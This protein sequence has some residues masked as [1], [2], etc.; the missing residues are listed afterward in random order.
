M[1]MNN[2]L[3]YFNKDFDNNISKSVLSRAVTY[4]RISSEGQS[5]FS[6]DSQ[7]KMVNDFCELNCIEIVKEFG[8]THESAKSDLSLIHI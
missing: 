6:I 5:N 4:T 7:V 1:T 2:E 8:G 3:E